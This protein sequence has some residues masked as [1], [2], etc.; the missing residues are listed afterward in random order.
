AAIELLVK[1]IVLVFAHV[2]LMLSL[3]DM[4]IMWGLLVTGFSF[5]NL[6]IPGA[7][8]SSYLFGFSFE[9]DSLSFK[10][11]ESIQ[12]RYF[13]FLDLELPVIR[14]E[15]WFNG[16]VSWE[17]SDILSGLTISSGE[18]STQSTQP[19]AAQYSMESEESLLDFSNI[20]INPQPTFQG[21]PFTISV[22]VTSADVQIIELEIE[23]R[24]YQMIKVVGTSNTWRA[25][26][27][28]IQDF[29][30][31]PFTIVAT[32]IDGTTDRF[33]GAVECLIPLTP[34]EKQTVLG[35]VAAGAI[36]P[37]IF[38]GLVLTLLG[39]LS[40]LADKD[41]TTFK[42]FIFIL[43]FA[44]L[45]ISLGLLGKNLWKNIGDM[46][47]NKMDALSLASYIVGVILGY[48]ITAIIFLI[49][50]ALTAIAS[51]I[52]SE[53]LSLGLAGLSGGWGLVWLIIK[54]IELFSGYPA[55]IIGQP[56]KHHMVAVVLV[57]LLGGAVFAG[58]SAVVNGNKKFSKDVGR[59]GAYFAI[60]AL[61]GVLLFS[62]FNKQ[63]F[64]TI[65]YTISTE[66][67][68]TYGG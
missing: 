20:I 25:E 62:L 51:P 60:V 68:E 26:S 34:E 45:V 17:E 6:A 23:G 55:G 9:S 56:L 10:Y 30:S 18:S 3:V 48:A 54:I 40:F 38:G 8:L 59:T 53:S 28:V 50:A 12:W 47:L 61:I 31:I 43:N 49:T 5:L 33:Y 4:L 39:I 2:M 36:S 27:I 52:S 35:R 21:I 57:I 24:N 65:L 42:W 46:I 66:L 11:E 7:L 13:N 41:K 58:I 64:G 15:T 16:Q 22:D 29:G 44:N 19:L 63:Y 1:A 14:T 32:A 67:G 37:M